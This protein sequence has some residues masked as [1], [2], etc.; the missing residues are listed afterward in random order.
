MDLEQLTLSL[1]AKADHKGPVPFHEE[2]FVLDPK[3]DHVKIP[4]DGWV[5]AENHKTWVCLATLP[6]GISFL[7][8]ETDLMAE[9]RRKHEVWCESID[10]LPKHRLIT[11]YEYRLVRWARARAQEI[12]ARS[13]QILLNKHEQ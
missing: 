3:G 5:H 12:I 8:K 7:G 10:A 9:E 4:D 6:I 13:N 11:T 2:D 1:V